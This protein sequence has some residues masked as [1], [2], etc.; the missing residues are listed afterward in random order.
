MSLFVVRLLHSSHILFD[1][2]SFIFVSEWLTCRQVLN[3][4]VIFGF[5]LNYALRVNLT[6][7]IVAM[8]VDTT[9]PT[10]PIILTNLT[11]ALNDTAHV[12]IGTDAVASLIPANNL[13][14]STSAASLVALQNTSSSWLD[15]VSKSI[16]ILIWWSSSGCI[17]LIS[18][19]TSYHG[20][21]VRWRWRTH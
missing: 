12:G 10:T 14:T 6:I 7:A 17:H 4:M 1:I 16:Y 18:Y 20:S 2:F 9:S 21:A 3:I 13:A 8:V 11:N 5:M 19:F 15:Q